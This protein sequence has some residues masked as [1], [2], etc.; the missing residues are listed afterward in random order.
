MQP[1]LLKYLALYKKLDI[2]GIGNFSVETTPATLQF[3]DKQW[4]PPASS[5]L[6]APVVHPTN[7]H[8]YSF[9]SR[10]WNVDKVIAIR[11][12]K[13]EVESTLEELKKLGICQLKGIGM[14]RKRSDGSLDFTADE[15]SLLMFSGLPAERV[16]RKHTQ[17]SV[18]V[19]EEEHI[20][21]Y[22]LPE[23]NEEV[24][25]EEPVDDKWKTYA[26]ILAIV[27]VLMIAYY[28]VTKGAS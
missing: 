26:M 8:F 19:G 3:T 13:E 5:I 12:Y 22:T 11:R 15:P 2:P 16:L 10:E 23:A 24:L 25:Y 17:H 9:L 20:K 28:Y 4:Q 27:A 7:N 18:L 14:L 1:A 6:F 21:T